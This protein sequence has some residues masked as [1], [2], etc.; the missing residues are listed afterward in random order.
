[1]PGKSNLEGG[2]NTDEDA[3]DGD[4]DSVTRLA[5]AADADAAVDLPMRAS[6]ENELIQ[7]LLVAVAVAV[8]AT[9]DDVVL[10]IVGGVIALEGETGELLVL[11]HI[12]L[13]AVVVITAAATVVVE[14][15]SLDIGGVFDVAM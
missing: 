11:R 6:M 7:G 10:V 3:G 1:M 5:D 2:E 15:V 8:V 12:V 13:A 4:V 14:V 9:V